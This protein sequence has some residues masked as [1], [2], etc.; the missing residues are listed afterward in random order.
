ME[1]ELIALLPRLRRFARALS[2]DDDAADDLVQSACERALSHADSFT[3]GTR[4]DSWMYRIVQN[5]W[6]DRCRSRAARPEAVPID[7]AMELEGSDGRRDTEA[8]LTLTRVRARVRGLPEEQR[9]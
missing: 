8:R 7:D 2:R 4:L 1:D 6:I 3:R 9:L 5:L